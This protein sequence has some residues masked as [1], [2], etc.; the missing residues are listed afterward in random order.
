[1]PPLFF[2]LKK[3]SV[4]FLISYYA[5]SIF[6]R[7]PERLALLLVDFLIYSFKEK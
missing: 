2:K 6:I 5:F 7:Y 4:H 3:V 1:M